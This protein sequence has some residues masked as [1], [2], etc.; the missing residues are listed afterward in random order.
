MQQEEALKIIKAVIDQ[1]IAKGLID[2]IDIAVK[3]AEAYNFII[4]ELTTNKD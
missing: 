2:N 3:I 4:S 1:S